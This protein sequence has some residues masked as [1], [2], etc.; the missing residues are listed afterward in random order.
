MSPRDPSFGGRVTPE[1]SNAITELRIV[2]E[3]LKEQTERNHNENREAIGGMRKEQDQANKQLFKLFGNGGNGE[4]GRLQSDV[5]DLKKELENVHMALPR[6][7][8]EMQ[9]RGATA[10]A[11]ILLALI[12]WMANWVFRESGRQDLQDR[13]ILEYQQRLMDLEKDKASKADMYQYFD[14]KLE[15]QRRQK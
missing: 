8:T 9:K 12:G 13:I 1:E 5:A 2:I 6:P 10:I 3:S 7:W 11:T 14:Q 4:H 15:E